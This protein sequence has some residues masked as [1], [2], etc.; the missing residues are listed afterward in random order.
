MPSTTDI[1]SRALPS[2]IRTQTIH[3]L[4]DMKLKHMHDYSYCTCSTYLVEIDR[5]TP[6]NV[7]VPRCDPSVNPI[8]KSLPQR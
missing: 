3:I 8:V 5:D 2:A 1:L 4:Q 7:L 6:L